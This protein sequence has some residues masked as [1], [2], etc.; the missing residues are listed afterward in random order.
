MASYLPDNGFV[1]QGHGDQ[2][3]FYDV[4]EVEDDVFAIGGN[5]WKTDMDRDSGVAIDEGEKLELRAGADEI[6]S[7]AEG[8]DH[9]PELQTTRR[10]PPQLPPQGILMLTFE[11]DRFVTVV[12]ETL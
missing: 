2:E 3:R 8:G 12:L 4:T 6:V 9:R 7:M 1:Q 10:G 11:H 5:P